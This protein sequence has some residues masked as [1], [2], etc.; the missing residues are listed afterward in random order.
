MKTILLRLL[1][2]NRDPNLILNNRNKHHRNIV[3]QVWESI[4]FNFWLNISRTSLFSFTSAFCHRL[5]RFSSS[6]E[7]T[8]L[9]IFGRTFMVNQ[10]HKFWPILLWLIPR[11]CKLEISAQCYKI[12]GYFSFWCP[13]QGVPMGCRVSQTRLPNFPD[14]VQMKRR[15]MSDKIISRSLGPWNLEKQHSEY[16]KIDKFG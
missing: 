7:S 14:F 4:V 2:N 1:L 11:L 16:T 9:P 8:Y 6:Y 5:D 13:R 3:F 10:G 12:S 15:Q